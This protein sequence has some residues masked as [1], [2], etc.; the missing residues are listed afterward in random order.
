MK[1]KMD[2]KMKRRE[3]KTESVAKG[4]LESLSEYFGSYLSALELV[5]QRN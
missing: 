5:S 1:K 4:S 2:K 3:S